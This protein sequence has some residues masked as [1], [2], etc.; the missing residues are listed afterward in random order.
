[1]NQAILFNED[2]EYNH[3]MQAWKFT[4]MLNGQLLTIYIK[5]NEDEIN[6]SLKFH[7]EEQVEDW[8][9]DNE[10]DEHNVIYL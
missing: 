3:Q 7:W 8:L 4:G 6:E 10:P 1:M 2:Y 5:G 9:E